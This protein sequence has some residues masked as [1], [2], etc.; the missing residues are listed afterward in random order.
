MI[1]CLSLKNLYSLQNFQVFLKFALTVLNKFLTFGRI[2][3][4]FKFEDCLTFNYDLS[5]N[6][7][8]N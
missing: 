7:K 1:F 3:N 4:Y 6:N 2:S 5:E 8:K